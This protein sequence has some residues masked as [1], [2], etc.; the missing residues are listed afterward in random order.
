MALS[1]AILNRILRYG[2]FDAKQHPQVEDWYN[3]AIV[4]E[5]PVAWGDLY[6]NAMAAKTAHLCIK[7]V[8]N[9]D[10]NSRGL[11]SSEPVNGAG[12]SRQYKYD[13]TNADWWR[14]TAP[15][16]RYADLADE[17]AG[18]AQGMPFSPLVCF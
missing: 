3:D 10:A 6:D 7:F 9:G 17:A 1:T 13:H 4:N 14:S 15:G 2:R 16:A 8:P 18:G 5:D 11:I 12:G